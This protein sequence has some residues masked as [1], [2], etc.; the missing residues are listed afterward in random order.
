MLIY[1][2][3]SMEHRPERSMKQINNMGTR[4]VKER[5]WAK[6][7]ENAC[8]VRFLQT[9]ELSFRNG[10]ILMLP[11]ERM[12]ALLD[13][14]DRHEVVSVD[15][16]SRY[17][18]V[19][20]ATVRRDIKELED[21]RKLIRTRGGAMTVSRGMTYEPAA[22]EKRS[23][24]IEEKRRIAQAAYKHLE[25]NETV[26]LDSGTTVLELARLMSGYAGVAITND[27]YIAAELAAC[28]HCDVI[29]I[30]GQIRRGVN[31]TTGYY[32]EMMLSGMRA[33][34]VFLGADAVHPE[35]G[36]MNANIEE[37]RMKQLMIQ[38]ARE[39]TL[40]CDH[41][42]FSREGLAQ[43]SGLQDIDRII[44]NK[45]LDAETVQEIRALDIELELV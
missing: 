42:K 39:K 6:D 45:E 3:C 24:Q 23:R 19:S 43:I 21:R 18:G 29:M 20:K 27:L 11:A 40:L 16:L 37:V 17:L 31:V 14:L 44:T 25:L 1:H 32:A 8:I 10:G 41:T 36:Y 2:R 22:H 5:I 33:D 30:G 4:T 13:Y 7:I 38:A 35:Y 12:Q 26:I 9:V 15:Y 28:I 34:K